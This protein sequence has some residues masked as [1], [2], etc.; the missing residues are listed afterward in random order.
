MSSNR[1]R[2]LRPLVVIMLVLLAFQYELGMAVNMSS[3]PSLPPV[4]PTLTALSDALNKAGPIAVLHGSVGG[5]LIL[6]SLIIMIVSL[7]SRVRSAQVFGTLAFLALLFAGDGGSQFVLSG[8]QNDGRSHE[9]ATM[10][11]LSFVF[12]FVELYVLKPG[13][14]A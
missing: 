1:I 7:A 2:A 5:L 12:Y 11:L 14:A 6:L 8:F 9:M 3:L 4:S 10:W 13:T